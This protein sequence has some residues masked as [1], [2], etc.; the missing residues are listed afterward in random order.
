MKKALYILAQ[1]SDRDFEWLIHTGKTKI[2]P[3]GTVLIRE[4]ERTDAL[5]LILDGT[6]AVSVESLAGVEIARL[7]AGEVV[8]EISFIDARPPTATVRAIEDAF[9]LTIPRRELVTKLSQDVAFS[10]NFYKSLATF[11]S[12]RLRRTVKGLGPDKPS[13]SQGEEDELNPHVSA[14]LDLAKAR[15]DWLQNRLKSLI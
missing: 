14:N 12:D 4:G 8:G 1:L 6:L 15:L 11:L 2:I 9:V 13:H 5:Y 10:S 3:S 7:E